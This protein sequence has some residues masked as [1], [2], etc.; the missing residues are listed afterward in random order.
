MN[1]EQIQAVRRASVRT[2]EQVGILMEHDRAR[3]L[4]AEAGADVRSDSHLVRIPEAVIEKALSTA[5]S[6]FLMAGRDESKDFLLGCDTPPRARPVM[7]LD[8]ILD[9]GARQR[10]AATTSDLESWV[11]VADALPN[12]SLVTGLYPWDA[13]PAVRDLRAAQA[14]LTYS[15]KPILIAPFAGAGVRRIAA[16]LALLPPRRGARAIIFSSSNSPLIYSESQMD[17]LLAAV[18]SDLPVMI[19]SSAVT[20]ATAPVTLAGSL[21]VMNA[22]IL[23]GI[24]VAQLARPGAPVIYAGHPI[25]LDLRTS[26]ASSG[27][28]EGGL[29]AAAMVELGRS[30]RLPTTSNGVTT[31]S[32]VCDEQAA[33]EKWITGYQA[34]AS[35]AALN[36]GAGTLGS[37][38][39]VSLE[40][41]VIDDEIYGRMFRFSEGIS[42]NADTLAFDVIAAV[43]P[44]RHYLEEEH[45]VRFM[46]REFRPSRL[47]NRQNPEVWIAQGGRD[48]VQL[49]AARVA[50]VLS[51]APELRCDKHV[52]EELEL[53]VNKR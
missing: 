27:Y 46:R 35:G 51:G 40:Q 53:V 1:A 18:A 9:H 39:T 17:V 45:T 21:V 37:L 24:T 26:I 5:P 36:G 2:L 6:E 47:A 4:L 28:T 31:D 49:A 29:L 48:I 34:L 3:S 8:W 50:E 19:N 32:H 30:Y 7:S 20:G 23:A 42:F 22:E 16:M 41:L 14:M 12:L 10:R 44:N 52:A 33:V 25:V 11:R 13:P 43:G 38:S 15:D